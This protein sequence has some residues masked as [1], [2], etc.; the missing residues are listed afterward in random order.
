[1]AAFG[2]I[3]YMLP[4]AWAP[5]PGIVRNVSLFYSD[6]PAITDVMASEVVS[7]DLSQVA[8][9][10]KVLTAGANGLRDVLGLRS[11]EHEYDVIWRFFQRL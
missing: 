8:I 11:R 2:S 9:T 6:H 4:V 1:M 3:G 5:T 7:A 10:L